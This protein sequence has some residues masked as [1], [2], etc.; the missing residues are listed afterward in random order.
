M[1]TSAWRRGGY[2]ICVAASMM[3][4]SAAADSPRRYDGYVVARVEVTDTAQVDNL[5][6]LDF[7]VWSEHVSTGSIDV[8]LAPEQLLA[9]D[10]LG[11]PYRIW[12]DDVQ[13]LI[14]RERAAAPRAW[15]ADYHPYEEIVTY[16][17]DLA[18]AHPTLAQ[19][20]EVGT[21]LEGRMIWALRVAGPEQPVTRPAVV[22]FCA[23]H[24]REWITT[25]V[26]PYLATHLLQQYGTDPTVTDL[27]DS[28]EWFL[29]PVANPDGYVYSWTDDRL[30]RK[31]RRDNG[32][33]E[34]GVDINRNWGFGW[35]GDGSSGYTGSQTY[36]G[37]EP[38]SEPETQA[39]RDFFLTH[40]NVRAQNDIHSYTQRILWPWGFQPDLPPDQP[41]YEAVGGTMQQLIFDVHGLSYEAG[42]IHSTIYPV[43]GGSVDWTYGVRD[44]FSFSYE[45]RDTGTYG[46][47][48]PAEQIIPNNEEILPALLYLTG[49]DPVRAT[50]I[51]FPDGLPQRLVAGEA[52]VVTATFTSGVET[53]DAGSATLH[54]RYDPQGPFTAVPMSHAGSAAFEAVLPA[55]NCS[56]QPEFYFSIVGESG[57]ILAPVDAPASTFAA[58]M[59]SGT[60]VFGENMDADPGGTTEGD[61][62]WGQPVGEGGL[63]GWPDP[64]E[65]HTGLNV[66]G[67]NLFGDYENNM[68]ER[69]LTSLPID[70]TGQWGLRLSFWRWLGV[71]TTPY[72]HASV[73]ISNDGITWTTIW[74]N[75]TGVED[76]V[77]I[78]QDFDVASVAD[79]QPNVYLRWTM[80]STDSG[81]AYCGWN[82]DD[83]QLYATGCE[84]IAGDHDGDDWIGPVDAAALGACAAGPGV[85]RGS[86]CGVFDFDEDAD[87]DLADVAAFQVVFGRP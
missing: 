83:I 72:D 68:P 13:Q 48:L 74:E 14:D 25:T 22:Y 50:Q 67:Y 49:S 51:R 45:L 73:R 46:F 47:L 64:E 57:T 21:S 63:H 87:V 61:W 9:L 56:S 29:I 27:V 60:I 12:I 7:D 44:I 65:G 39:L 66:Y 40:P 5:L 34:W 52:M 55:T 28:V 58:T 20:V 2:A 53:L 31:N 59:V 24:A 82:I 19:M 38:F 43:S 84:G 80:G 71:E 8:M 1:A 54:Y 70:C 18:T 30:W 41:V 75:E 17:D 77:W 3:S 86:G 62:A 26:V 81:W 23:V 85:E 76:N 6:A 16:L 79:N 10:A 36:R 42:P 37:P 69:H 78:H 32:D 33:G 15:F 35:G 4:L 11:L